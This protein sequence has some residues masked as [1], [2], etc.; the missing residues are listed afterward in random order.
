M[1]FTAR[2]SGNFKTRKGTVF[3]VTIERDPWTHAAEPIKIVALKFGFRPDK[4]NT[5]YTLFPS[6]CTIVVAPDDNGSSRLKGLIGCNEREYKVVVNGGIL[7]TFDFWVKPSQIAFPRDGV[8]PTTLI[9][10]SGLNYL[11]DETYAQQTTP[12]LVTYTGVDSFF[13]IL[14]RGLESTGL[15]FAFIVTNYQW[16]ARSTGGYE[17]DGEDSLVHQGVDN[18]IFLDS[19]SGNPFTMYEVFANQIAAGCDL[20]VF[21]WANQWYLLQ[22]RRNVNLSTNEQ[23]LYLHSTL[24]TGPALFPFYLDIDW[25][26]NFRLAG[27]IESHQQAKVSSSIVYNHGVPQTGVIGNPGFE[28]G[29]INSTGG[30]LIGEWRKAGSNT[31]IGTAPGAGVDGS[32]A[33]YQDARLNDIAVVNIPDDIDVSHGTFFEQRAGLVEGGVGRK[34]TLLFKAAIDFSEEV[35]STNLFFFPV[36][37]KIIGSTTTWTVYRD[38]A[39]G[40]YKLSDTVASPDDILVFQWNFFIAY[41]QIQ[42]PISELHD[43]TDATTG[44]LYI[45]VYP[46]VQDNI[47]QGSVEFERS[48]FDDFD[49]VITEASGETA[50]TATKTTCTDSAASN[51]S[52]L[53]GPTVLFG[54]GP[55]GGHIRRIRVLDDVG[56]EDGDA[57]DFQFGDDYM[58]SASGLSRDALFCDERLKQSEIAGGQLRGTVMME[59]DLEYAPYMY[60]RD[61]RTG[62]VDVAITASDTD[63]VVRFDAADTPHK[64]P[65]AGFIPKRDVTIG[66]ETFKIDEVINNGDGTYTV[67]IDGSFAGAHAVDA[68]VTQE[69]FYS[70]REISDYDVYDNTVTGIWDEYRIGAGGDTIVETNIKPGSPEAAAITSTLGNIIVNITG[71]AGS[72]ITVVESIGDLRNIAP[73]DNDAV[74]LNSVVAG[75]ELGAGMFIADGADTSTT[76]NTG[77]VVAGSNNVRFKRQGIEGAWRVEWFGALFDG[78]N[79]D[80]SAFQNCIDAAPAGKEIVLPAGLCRLGAGV[81]IDGKAITIRGENA[82]IYEDDGRTGFPATPAGSVILSNAA[83]TSPLF[84]VQD[85]ATIDERVNAVRF[86]DIKFIG[87]RASQNEGTATDLYA[88]DFKG[89]WKGEVI[90]C[91][92]SNFTSHGIRGLTQPLGENEYVTGLVIDDTWIGDCGGYGIFLNDASSVIIKNCI[93]RDNLSGGIWEGPESLGN[94]YLNNTIT[95]NTGH[96]AEFFGTG[97]T[98]V[99]GNILT[100]NT[101]RGIYIGNASFDTPDCI[102]TNNICFFNGSDDGLGADERSGLVIKNLISSVVSNNSLSFNGAY[103]LFLSDNRSASLAGNRGENNELGFVNLETQNPSGY[104][105]VLEWSGILQQGNDASLKLQELIDAVPAGSTLFFPRGDYL[106]SSPVTIAKTLTLIGEGSPGAGGDIG[107]YFAAAG[108]LDDSLIKINSSGV[109][110]SDI[111]FFGSLSAPSTLARG[112]TLQAGAS[113]GIITRCVF[114]QFTGVAIRADAGSA[115]ITIE[116]CRFDN[117]NFHGLSISGDRIKV[118]SC[119]AEANDGI[120]V[121]IQ[122]ANDTQVI[123]LSVRSS[124]ESGV[125]IE[126]GRGV[127]LE[128]CKSILNDEAGFR[129]VSGLNHSI[130]GCQAYGNGVD[131]TAGD[132]LR[133][134]IYIQG[135]DKTLITNNWSGDDV[136]GTPTQRYAISTGS[137][138]GSSTILHNNG[139][140][141][142]A[143]FF[144]LDSTTAGNLD[145]DLEATVTLNFGTI[146]TGASEVIG[147]IS[148]PG[149]RGADAVKLGMPAGFPS[150][151]FA[152]GKVTANDTLQIEAFN[153]SGSNQDPDSTGLDW[154][155]HLER[156]GGAAATTTPPDPPAGAIVD[157]QFDNPNL[158]N[159]A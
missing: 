75:K 19:E 147:S 102:V 41:N 126:S 24:A 96:G 107:T 81:T 108:T 5:F 143:G 65:D 100:G 42:I 139:D 131:T 123:G 29:P 97:L 142:A 94:S 71:S 104:Y 8:G 57:S 26:N 10:A 43:G 68:A 128:A 153:F 1:A 48:L 113:D 152:Q 112:I 149:A 18:I 61:V 111:N 122:G 137:S 132:A 91:Q 66:A 79:D 36:T 88:I 30:N 60:L 44:E 40:L 34:L 80:S 115:D 157:I 156:R 84:T 47:G 85:Q 77:T 136:G 154:S 159:N 130:N 155:V 74:W 7:G 83:I 52:E 58:Q 78:V 51:T 140:G 90:R 20:Q 141:N 17:A 25:Q 55:T 101:G 23:T 150:G 124:G 134:G 54:S 103:G 9:A 28:D 116:G 110:I 49:F 72:G 135:G 151:F 21:K 106:F 82:S 35:P 63:F 98:R 158:L 32:T 95:G 27:F 133:S 129:I 53:Q 92:I 120:G 109:R 89:V 6:S 3:P 144:N 4:S 73:S 50:N 2:Y 11:Q 114:Y 99:I 118:V 16:F 22:R 15:D 56:A 87:N 76:D 93:V 62:R 146:N 14:E 38:P 121:Y 13:D 127:S 59:N 31:T 69:I 148:I 105:N 64:R 117:N 67:E 45:A 138:V 119:Y 12:T 46:A 70:P 33:A 39:D 125:V 86:Q 145:I 37:V